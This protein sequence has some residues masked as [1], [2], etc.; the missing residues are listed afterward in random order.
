MPEVEKIVY[1]ELSYRIVGCA[2]R[3]HRALGPGFPEVVY[4]RALEIEFRKE[5]IMFE[6]QKQFAVDYEGT[7]VGNFRAD[8]LV[9]DKV[10][11]ELKA[12]AVMPTVYSRQLHSYL[13]VSKLRLG[14]LLNF[15]RERLE[16]VRIVY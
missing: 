1:K 8:Y 12:L 7:R 14:M 11:L 9:E 2:M 3:V 13:Q 5:G 16:N 6:R 10:N 15:G 4:E